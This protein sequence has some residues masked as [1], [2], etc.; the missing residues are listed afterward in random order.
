MKIKQK[1]SAYIFDIVNYTFLFLVAFIT[2]YPMWYILIISLSSD[3]YI[4]RGAVS[5]WPRG[6]TFGAYKLVVEHPDIW[7]SY[8]N[9]IIYTTVGTLINMVF[10]SLCA[11]SDVISIKFLFISPSAYQVLNCSTALV[12]SSV[13]QALTN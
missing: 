11:F 4:S 10:T 8:G 12:Y 13:S 2:L 7:R 1:P 9:T 3:Y 6:F 5:V